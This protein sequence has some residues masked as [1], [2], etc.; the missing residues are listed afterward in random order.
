MESLELEVRG[1]AW[2]GPSPRKP[3]EP[4]YKD[5]ERCE[6]VVAWLWQHGFENRTACPPHR[7]HH[8]CERSIR[9]DRRDAAL[10][11]RAAVGVASARRWLKASLP[12]HCLDR[13]VTDY[14]GDCEYGDTGDL[15]M[16]E[17][18]A[19]SDTSA[20]RSC[21]ERCIR[22]ARC[23]F[24]SV[25]TV[26]RLC[27]WHHRCDLENLTRIDKRVKTG[28]WDFRQERGFCSGPRLDRM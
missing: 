11:K 3:C 8:A 5:Q 24:V 12:G 1:T 2:P 23:R 6:D 20:V 16:S 17:D 27:S 21:L 26:A 18:E 10:P 22:C 19:L 14:G 15:A 13:V 9:F 28:P 25:S 4:L 7:K